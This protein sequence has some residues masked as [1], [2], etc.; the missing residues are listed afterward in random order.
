MKES[1]DIPENV[2]DW[3][4]ECESCVQWLTKASGVYLEDEDKLVLRVNMDDTQ[5]LDTEDNS[6]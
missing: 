6:K 1:S 4:L 5:Q 3:V 2:D